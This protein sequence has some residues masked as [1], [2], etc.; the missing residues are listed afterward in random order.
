MGGAARLDSGPSRFFEQGYQLEWSG[1]AREAFE[2]SAM[3]HWL[4]DAYMLA[5]WTELLLGH[6]YQLF[7]YQMFG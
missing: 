5:L 2:A 4:R 3:P 7:T 6:R 1:R